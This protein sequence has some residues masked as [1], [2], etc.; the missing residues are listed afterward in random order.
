MTGNFSE[1]PHTLLYTGGTI[2]AAGVPLTPLPAAEFRVR[3]DAA[4]LLGDAWWDATA[5]PIDSTDATPADWATIARHV[6]AAPGAVTILHGTDTMAWTAAA[7]GFLLTEI[8]PEG[9]PR[10]RHGAPVIFTG[11][12]RPLFGP[13]EGANGVADGSDAPA[14]LALARNAANDAQRD[15]RR[16]VWLAFGGQ[17]LPGTRALKADTLADA[18][19]EAPLEP[20]DTPASAPASVPTALMEL[21]AAQPGGLARQLDEVAPFL[22]R[23]MVLSVTAAPNAPH[24]HAAVLSG[25]ITALGPSLGAILLLGYGLGNMPGQAALAP[26]LSAAAERGVLIAAGSQVPRGP[27]WPTLYAAGHWLR[28][29]GA[30]P[31]GD[32][33]AAAMHAKLH[34]VLALAAARGWDGER[35]RAV[36]TTPLA[37]EMSA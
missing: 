27:V 6:L 9:K 20:V 18:A 13:G 16:G 10:A 15:G 24:H 21:P 33:T 35:A 23:R 2:G 29:L 4:G 32:M 37:G 25:A 17:V 28:A 1:A 26:I 12:Q 31:A 34:V 30:V 3:V 5:R 36:L 22:G 14:N 8:D 11:S 7:L 19:F